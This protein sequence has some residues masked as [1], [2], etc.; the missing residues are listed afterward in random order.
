MTTSEL[1]D[2]LR[3]KLTARDLEISELHRL[4][5]QRTRERDEAVERAV[6]AERE[7]ERDAGLE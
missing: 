2:N 1:L 7:I 5:A 3:E 4:L 6:W